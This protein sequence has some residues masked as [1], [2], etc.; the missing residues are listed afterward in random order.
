MGSNSDGNSEIFL[1]DASAGLSQITN[2]TSGTSFYPAINAVGNRISFVSRSNLVGSN[3]DGNSEIFL[4][5]SSTG[6]TQ[7][8]NTS[9]L[10]G[11]SG[12]S[13][14]NAAG[15]RIAFESNTN[16]VG[17]NGDANS[18]IFL[19][20]ASTGL[21]Q[22]TN[23]TIGTSLLPAIDAAGDRI[24]FRSDAP[25]VSNSDRN[26]EIF[27]WD[28]STGFTQVTNTTDGNS[29]SPAINA[30]GNRIAFHSV[31]PWAATAI[32]TAR[33]FCSPA[34]HFWPRR[35]FPLSLRSVSESWRFFSALPLPGLSGG[36]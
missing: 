27:L 12:I 13:A 8:T 9:V 21:T 25:L 7:I 24:A 26:S 34:R 36:G 16:L 6:F 23:T 14:I 31:I 18:E 19:W 3:G 29:D 35:R 30:A 17:S 1:W 28:A 2:T 20:D 22:I 11:N 33:S 4:W 5:D 15:N 32:G 10:A